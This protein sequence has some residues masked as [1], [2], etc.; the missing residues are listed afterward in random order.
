MK[1]EDCAK[2]LGITAQHMS[3]VL[4]GQRNLSLKTARLA[5]EIFG[6]SLEIWLDPN[7]AANRRRLTGARV[8]DKRGRPPTLRKEQP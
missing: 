4:R 1:I 3:Y 5:R 7:H 2:L 6:G 8:Y